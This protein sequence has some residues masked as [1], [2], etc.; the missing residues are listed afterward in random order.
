ME[1]KEIE[2][3]GMDKLEYLCL[4]EVVNALDRADKVGVEDCEVVLDGFVDKKGSDRNP[5]DPY[6]LTIHSDDEIVGQINE[7]IKILLARAEESFDSKDFMNA[8][9]GSVSIMATGIGVI[10]DEEGEE[11]YED[12]STDSNCVV[13]VVFVPDWLH[14]SHK[15]I[16]CP[17]M[18]QAEA[19]LAS[20]K[21]ETEKEE[22]NEGCGKKKKKKT[23]KHLRWIEYPTDDA[24]EI[25]E[26]LFRRMALE[27]T[28]PS[29]T[30]EPARTGQMECKM[31]IKVYEEGFDSNY[32]FWDGH[33]DEEDYSGRTDKAY[34]E[35]YIDLENK[36]CVVRPSGANPPKSDLYS[37]AEFNGE[38][39][40][41][42]RHIVFLDKSDVDTLCAELDKWC[43]LFAEEYDKYGEVSPETIH[44]FE[45]DYET[46][47]QIS[48]ENEQKE[49]EDALD[50][51]NVS[52]SAI[53][54]LAKETVLEVGKNACNDLIFLR[55]VFKDKLEDA[56][57]QDDDEIISLNYAVFA[58]VVMQD[59]YKEI[60]E[61]L[62]TACKDLFPEEDED[63]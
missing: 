46:W 9:I 10:K 20:V 59:A 39:I 54:S 34:V 27:Q 16:V 45:K 49:F 43:D 41:F 26:E 29:W 19:V 53:E 35:I 55:D 40:S 28:S 2:E 61:A 31:E 1:I 6:L 3:T 22:E 4:Q 21:E 38:A 8:Y 17:S 25:S 50:H 33:F 62:E 57:A 7:A 5:G 32:P 58:N 30:R 48:V 47:E 37:Q 14:R 42:A 13:P 63:E 51:L 52:D 11:E 44:D 60:D 12:E 36:K 24:E 56:L 18:E 23:E 15:A